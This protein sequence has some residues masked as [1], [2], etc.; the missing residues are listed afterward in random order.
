MYGF[1]YKTTNTLTNKIYIGQHIPNDRNNYLGSG[2]LLRRAVKKYGKESFKVDI[3]EWCNS[4]DE[5]DSR[6]R[7]YID[8]YKSRDTTIGYNITRGGQKAFFTGCKH[9]EESKMKMSDSARKRPHQPTT[10]GRL[11]YTDGNINKT[12]KPEEVEEY[13]SKGWH[14][15][16]TLKNKTAWNKGLTKYTDARVA[17]YSESRNEH[18]KNGESIGCFGVK[19]NTYGFVKGDIP[20][21][22]GLKGYNKGHPNY[23]LGKKKNK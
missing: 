18:F 7:Y 17:K 22:K 6:E 16:R 4:Q 13:E 5:L 8:L 3:L 11:H 9:S 19:G 10:N 1:I 12:I 15:G 23:Y 14:R 21:N 20:W 2:T